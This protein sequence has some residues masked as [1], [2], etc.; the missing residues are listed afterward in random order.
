MQGRTENLTKRTEGGTENLTKR[1]EG[2]TA[3]LTN[4][5]ERGTENLT[6]RLWG[7]TENLTKRT[8]RTRKHKNIEWK[9]T[10]QRKCKAG[11]K[12]NKENRRRDGIQ[13]KIMKGGTETKQR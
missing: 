5:M 1:M 9:E 11:Q 12:P 3:N 8:E 6:K 13:T 2:G 7:R 10:K 4:R